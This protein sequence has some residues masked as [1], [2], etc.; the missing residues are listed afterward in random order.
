MTNE[1]IKWNGGECPVVNDVVLDV[2]Y[3]FGNKEFELITQAMHFNWKTVTYY[4]I[5]QTP[6]ELK[7]EIAL[8]VA[9][10]ALGYSDSPDLYSYKAQSALVKIAELEKIV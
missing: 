6:R 1:W 3:K 5:Y 2:K 4:R 8:A 10:E 9:K 7:L